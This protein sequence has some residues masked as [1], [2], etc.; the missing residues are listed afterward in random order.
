MGR[1]VPFLMV[2]KE[3]KCHQVDERKEA[4]LEHLHRGWTEKY[5]STRDHATVRV[6]QNTS[7]EILSCISYFRHNIVMYGVPD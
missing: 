5:C 2:K 3:L 7:D 6:S 1:G 4:K